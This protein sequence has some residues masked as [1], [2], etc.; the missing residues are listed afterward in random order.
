MN[1]TGQT[2]YYFISAY[3][4]EDGKPIEGITS[5]QFFDMD[6]VEQ[7]KDII[8]KFFYTHFPLHLGGFRADE[9]L[10]DTTG[11]KWCNLE[12]LRELEL[13]D[14]IVGLAIA[15]GLIK[16]D[17]IE[18]YSSVTRMYPRGKF[19]NREEFNLKNEEDIKNYLDEVRDYCLHFYI[20][21]VD[22]DAYYYMKNLYDDEYEANLPK[23]RIKEIIIDWLKTSEIKVLDSDMERINSYFAS[24]FENFINFIVKAFDEP[25]GATSFIYMLREDPELLMLDRVTSLISKYTEK[26]LEDFENHKKVF[27]DKITSSRAKSRK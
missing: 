26:Q 24:D 16:D 13:L 18:R 23:E 4:K 11:S 14:M 21:S 25:D 19:L 20:L 15:V 10:Y 7:N 22:F 6:L 2:I 9:W 3:L 1:K 27:F 5:Y 8:L 12:D 17:L